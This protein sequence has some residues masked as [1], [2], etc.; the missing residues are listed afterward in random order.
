[1]TEKINY[2]SF[3]SKNILNYTIVDENIKKYIKLWLKYLD[4]E[5]GFSKRT[6]L[7]YEIDLRKFINFL[8]WLKK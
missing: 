1:M 6:I 7:S 5:K 8:C 4:L 2:Y 3:N